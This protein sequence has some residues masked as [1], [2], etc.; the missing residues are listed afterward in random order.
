[1][2]ILFGGVHVLA[3]YDANFNVPADP[4]MAE[5][6]RLAKAY[7]IPMGPCTPTAFGLIQIL[8]V[9]YSLLLIYAGVLNLLAMGPAMRAGR[10]RALAMC[11]ILFI[12]LLLGVLVVYQFP[13]PML[14]AGTALVLFGVSWVKQRG[15]APDGP[16]SGD[17]S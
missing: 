11:N 5:I 2:L 3:V 6:D 7:T 16:I 1:M 10:L 12:A 8:S 17:N 4:K 9:S 15:G 14:F 13:P